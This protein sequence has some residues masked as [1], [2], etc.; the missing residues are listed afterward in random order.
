MQ[1][2]Q[3]K[4]FPTLLTGIGVI[5][6]GTISVRSG[7]RNYILA[8]LI[9]VGGYSFICDKSH[10][11]EF[12]LLLLAANRVLTIGSISAPTIVMIIG[13][14]RMVR[15]GKLKMRIPLFIGSIVFLILSTFT[16]INGVS[17]LLSS[18]KTLIVLWFISTYTDTFDIKVTYV[19]LVVVCATGCLITALLTMFIDPSSILENYRFS[20]TGSGGENILGILCS[21]FDLNLMCIVLYGRM[22]NHARYFV[23]IA[24][25]TLII[26]LTGSRSAMLCL[27]VGIVG[28]FLMALLKQNYKQ[29]ILILLIAGIAAAIIYLALRDRN[30]LSIYIDRFMNR[31]QKYMRSDISNGRFALW[32]M[33]LSVFLENPLLLW[34]GGMDYSLYG[35]PNVAHNMIIEQL[36][37]YGIVGSAAALFLYNTVYHDIKTR[38]GTRAVL[39][40]PRSIPLISFLIASMT[41]H[42]LLGVPQTMMLCISACGLLEGKR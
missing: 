36:A 16:Y 8:A 32:S 15:N 11:F 18:L 35:I 38:S 25:L 30:I 4:Q 9:M 34:F 27:F 28:I 37:G 41:S 21:V 10:M 6:L 14:A 39:I 40:S 12:T 5:L 29:I 3:K 22:R 1:L 42:T 17:Q 26:L 24:I 31:N 13:S 19:N 7:S 2:K 20:L 33:Y 23:Y